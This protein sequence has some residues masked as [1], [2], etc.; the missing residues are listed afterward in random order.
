MYIA[1]Y[2]STYFYRIQAI[3]L[4]EQCSYTHIYHSCHRGQPTSG[5]QCESVRTGHEQNSANLLKIK[6]VANAVLCH[7]Y[8]WFRV[9][10]NFP[11][12][13]HC[14]THS[15]QCRL[16]AYKSASCFSIVNF[17]GRITY[18][19]IAPRVSTS[20]ASVWFDDRK[21]NPLQKPLEPSIAFELK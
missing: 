3:L 1:V 9:L 7:T 6:I 17:V 15:L 8:A 18:R 14:V 16:Y 12:H 20:V 2:N 10:L 11:P 5:T 13:T 4:N 19:F 21:R